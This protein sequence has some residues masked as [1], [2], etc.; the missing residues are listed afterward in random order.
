MTKFNYSG[1]EIINSGEENNEF[2]ERINKGTKCIG[3]L[4]TSCTKIK[5]KDGLQDN[6]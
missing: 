6:N 1:V 2:Q 4:C 5:N 3:S